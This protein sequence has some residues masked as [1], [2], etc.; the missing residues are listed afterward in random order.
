MLNDGRLSG[1]ADQSD[2]YLEHANNDVKIAFCLQLCA[3]C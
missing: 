2:S 3:V 1:K